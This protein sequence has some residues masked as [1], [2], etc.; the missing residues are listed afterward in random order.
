VASER[1]ARLRL[2]LLREESGFSLASLFLSRL[3]LNPGARLAAGIGNVTSALFDE[4]HPRAID[5]LVFGLLDDGGF[6]HL[7][8]R[9]KID[10]CLVSR[11]FAT[12]DGR[13]ADKLSGPRY[14]LAE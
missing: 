4:S 5:P 9:I 13:G 14:W 12:S 3:L 10:G 8:R 1:R 7:L 6:D 2:L 11:S